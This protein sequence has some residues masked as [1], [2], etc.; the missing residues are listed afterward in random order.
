MPSLGVERRVEE[1]DRLAGFEHVGNLIAC[2][3]IAGEACTTW[4]KL[5]ELDIHSFQEHS[6]S[7]EGWNEVAGHYLR[8]D[9]LL[10]DLGFHGLG[11]DHGR[12]HRVRSSLFEL[13]NRLVAGLLVVEEEGEGTKSH[14]NSWLPS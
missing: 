14:G 7:W 10:P 11:H 2:E 12:Q 13:R 6:C 9:V 1:I 8:A 5:G 3:D 4:P